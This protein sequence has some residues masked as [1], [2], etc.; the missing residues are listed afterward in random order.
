MCVTDQL[1]V[2]FT[3]QVQI[4]VS[5]NLPF[6]LIGLM[7]SSHTDNSK[8]SVADCFFRSCI[9]PWFYL[10]LPS[11][12]SE[13]RLEIKKNLLK[14]ENNILKKKSKEHDRAIER[15]KR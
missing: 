12:T 2:T 14:E 10:A 15:H 4:K 11:V 6:L 8:L 7:L 9:I 13:N 1:K 5:N 3:V